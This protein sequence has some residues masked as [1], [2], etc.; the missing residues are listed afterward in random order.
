MSSDPLEVY[1]SVFS[2][3]VAFVYRCRNDADYQMEFMDGRVEELC[4]RPPSDILNNHKVGYADLIAAE[5]IQKV[6][7][8]V[9]GAIEKNT[10][11]DVDYRLVRPNGEHSYVRERGSAVYDDAGE[12]IYLEG[13]VVSAY[14]EVDLRETLQ[15]NAQS[16]QERSAEIHQ[17]AS[18]I[19]GA[20]NKLSLLSVNARIEAARSGEAGAGFSVIAMEIRE[21]AD[22]SNR[23]AEQIA[24]KME[25]GNETRAF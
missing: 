19:I 7:D 10:Y 15:S 6:V 25:V 12:M 3:G 16:A 22:E 4:G 17:L 14:A 18:N 5:D 13:L 20:V 2:S 23:W 24:D 8:A 9:D 11:W 1:K 21:L